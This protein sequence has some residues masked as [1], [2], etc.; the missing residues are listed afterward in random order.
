MYVLLYYQ[1]VEAFLRAPVSKQASAVSPPRR[2]RTLQQGYSGGGRGCVL[3]FL[4]SFWSCL[5][6]QWVHCSS[7]HPPFAAF[8]TSQQ[9]WQL[10]EAQ[11]TVR[12]A[13]PLAPYRADDWSS[14]AQES[15]CSQSL[16]RRLLSIVLDFP[17]L[18]V[19]FSSQSPQRAGFRRYSGINRCHQ[20]GCFRT[21]H[22]YY[23]TVSFS[24]KQSGS[25][26]CKTGLLSWKTNSVYITTLAVTAWDEYNAVP[27][28]VAMNSSVV[29]TPC[30]CYCCCCLL[31][32]RLTVVGA[33]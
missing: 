28:S 19:Q 11:P 8:G 18:S 6:L 33:P 13:P 17:E 4:A 24:A 22:S 29:S 31:L 12:R 9:D 16:H 21:L 5:L 23:H 14:L 15:P 25:L 20:T 26:Q 1:V 30:C 2:A 10:A 27:L 3:L 32:L 7:F